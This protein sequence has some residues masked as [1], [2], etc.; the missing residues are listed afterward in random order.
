MSDRLDMTVMYATHNKL[1]R[2]L[3]HIA[4]ATARFESEPR[5]ILRVGADWE[6]F[7]RTLSAHQSA[8][9]DALWPPLRQAL[10]GRP[11]DLT[12]LE[13]MEAEHAAIAALVGAINGALTAPGIAL[14]LFGELTEAL[15]SGLRGHLDHEEEALFPLVQAALGEDAWDRFRQVHARR[16]GPYAPQLLPWLLDGADEQTV[17]SVLASFPAP[18][19][20]AYVHRWR[21]SSEALDRWSA[22]ATVP[23]RPEPT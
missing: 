23:A 17:S 20:R 13:A 5:C 15:L 11:Y 12:R 6:M 16:V 14:D 1:R 8:E 21:L 9:D 10:E 19:R 22:E 3:R 2:E 4:Q 18:A 7:R